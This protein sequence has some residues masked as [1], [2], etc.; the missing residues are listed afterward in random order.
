[1]AGKQNW[2][3]RARQLANA[4]DST[5]KID[6]AEVLFRGQAADE[7]FINGL[8]AEGWIKQRRAYYLKSVWERFNGLATKARLSEIGWTRLARCPRGKELELVK[9]VEKKTQAGR[10]RRDGDNTRARAILLRMNVDQYQLFEKAL[11]AFG[12][13]RP[14][15]G[16][17]LAQKEEALTRALAE[18]MT[19]LR[20]KARQR[21]RRNAPN[22]PP[23]KE[24]SRV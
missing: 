5:G 3:Q 12:A 19:E 17:G 24:K 16:L 20:T 18:L 11:L 4:S 1:M 2:R 15:N 6:L 14:R 21:A 23:R 13:K 9:G 8:L 22:K 7:D 10:P